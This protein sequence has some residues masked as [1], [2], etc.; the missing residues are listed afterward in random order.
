MKIILEE[1]QPKM[2]KDSLPACAEKKFFNYGKEK[3]QF[4]DEISEESKGQWIQ[5]TSE[6]LHEQFKSLMR[7]TED[8]GEEINNVDWSKLNYETYGADYYSEKFEGFD[9]KIYQILADSSKSENAI[10]DKRIPSL[11][12]TD[13]SFNPFLP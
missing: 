13:G 4:I 7:Y 2:P 10:L 12:K 3:V 9:P 11:K 5:Y 6:E 1:D 8:G